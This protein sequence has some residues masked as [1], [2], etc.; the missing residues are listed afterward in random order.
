MMRR[1]RRKLGVEVLLFGN[2]KLHDFLYFKIWERGVEDLVF[3]V[4]LCFH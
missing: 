3:A 2:L 1:R 4:L